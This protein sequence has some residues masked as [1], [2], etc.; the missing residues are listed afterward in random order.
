MGGSAPA[1]T[2]PASSPAPDTCDR[3]L[4]QQ[5]INIL[6]RTNEINKLRSLHQAI[7]DDK[8]DDTSAKTAAPPRRRPGDA[9]SSTRLTAPPTAMPRSQP[10]EQSK[11]G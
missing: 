5:F 8:Q 4:C 2:S 7:A 6:A 1:V 10:N 9:C 3:D 11:Q